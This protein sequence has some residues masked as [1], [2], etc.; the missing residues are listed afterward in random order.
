[1]AYIQNILTASQCLASAMRK[2]VKTLEKL[3]YFAW[4]MFYILYLVVMAP[5][6]FYLI[7]SSVSEEQTRNTTLMK[8]HITHKNIV[9]VKS[10]V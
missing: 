7:N 6:K 5:W 8:K 2:K 4:I 3:I 10:N 9:C 1:M